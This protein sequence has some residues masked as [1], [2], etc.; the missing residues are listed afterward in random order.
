[1]SD[2][3]SDLRD[4]QY[5]FAEL[6]QSKPLVEKRLK[7]VSAFEQG[8]QAFL[9]DAEATSAFSDLSE[10]LKQAVDQNVEVQ[11]RCQIVGVSPTAARDQEVYKRVSAAVVMTCDSETLT[12]ILYGLETSN[13]YLFVD[14][15]VLYRQA[16]TFQ[17]G[18]KAAPAASLLGAQF[19]LSG[20]LRQSGK[21]KASK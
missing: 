14:R 11:S 7:E 10:R 1:M 4:Q 2:Q 8:N 19:T 9:S 13:P 21:S 16:P 17:P 20:Y 18:G 6:I 3:Y 15:L 12:K 5:R